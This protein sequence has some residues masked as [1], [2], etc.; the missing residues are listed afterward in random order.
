MRVKS[1]QHFWASSAP[2]LVHITIKLL[3]QPIKL[4]TI[5]RFYGIMQIHH[6]MK[7]A[8]HMKKQI[9]GK[10]YNTAAANKI[11]SNGKK[12]L[13]IKQNG[14]CFIAAGA[15][16]SPATWGAAVE[17]ARECGA[18]SLLECS[19]NYYTSK[20]VQ[21]YP[22]ITEQTACELRQLSSELDMSQSRLVEYAL[23]DFLTHAHAT[24]YGLLQLN[25]Y[26]Q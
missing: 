9:K 17:L 13:Y 16:L 24:I 26:E 5:K 18:L 19:Y 4:L 12:T 15:T 23:R 11:C 1:V 22:Q 3:N 25:V 2:V 21:L 10:R 8:Y 6:Q 20:R 7:G 14:E